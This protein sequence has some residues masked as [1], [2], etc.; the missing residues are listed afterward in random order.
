MQTQLDNY[1]TLQDKIRIELN[2]YGNKY[3]PLTVSDLAAKLRINTY[4]VYQ[5]LYRLKSKGEIE[6]DKKE[7]DNG[8]SSIIGVNIIKLEPSGRTYHRAAERAKF[9]VVGTME[10]DIEGQMTALQEY[11][12]QKLAIIDMQKQAEEAG[13]NPEETIR[14]EPNQYAEEGLLLLKLIGDITKDLKETKSKLQ[15]TEFDLEAERRNVEYLT[16]Q[17]REETRRELIASASD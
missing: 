10:E 2:Q 15:M 14:F 9:E 11:L 1:L 16:N 3:V 5:A 17:K 13:L 7:S 6:L 4:P 8:R 12:N